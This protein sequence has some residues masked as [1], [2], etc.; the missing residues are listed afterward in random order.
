MRLEKPSLFDRVSRPSI[1]TRIGAPRFPLPENHLTRPSPIAPE[2]DTGE[3]PLEDNAEF[4]PAPAED[5]PSDTQSNNQIRQD[6]A[7]A[8]E[9]QRASEKQ[10][11]PKKK[12]P[13]KEKE[14]QAQAI[15]QEKLQQKQTAK[16]HREEAITET[17]VEESQAPLFVENFD[18]DVFFRDVLKMTFDTLATIDGMEKGRAQVFYL[19]CPPED[20]SIQDECGVLIEF[21]KK[22]GGVV[23]SNRFVEEDWERFVR[24]I[25]QGVVVVCSTPSFHN[26]LQ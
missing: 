8:A 9:D 2:L 17:P 24:T 13:C 12:G 21:L 22:H 23:F 26:I 6:M 16:S 4:Q 15:S 1:S 20:A 18:V 10:P 3:A 14:G 5:V 25:N 19:M 7:R 11:L